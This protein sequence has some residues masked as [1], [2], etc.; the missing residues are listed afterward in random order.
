[1]SL[2]KST[3]QGPPHLEKWLYTM[4]LTMN[5]YPNGLLEAEDIIGDKGTSNLGH[6]SSLPLPQTMVLKVI[7]VH[8][9]WH[10]QYHLGQTTHMDP[11][12]P[13]EAEDIKKKCI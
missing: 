12:V 6:P 10:L 5:E 4:V 9:P 11:N 2:G 3:P 1:M 7:G 13:D 8:C